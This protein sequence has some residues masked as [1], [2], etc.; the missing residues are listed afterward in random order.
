MESFVF[1][2]NDKLKL[3][4]YDSLVS[5]AEKCEEEFFEI[6][7][8]SDEE[9]QVLF[10]LLGID[11]PAEQDLSNSEDFYKL[12]DY[13]SYKLPEFNSEQFDEFYDA[14]LKR[15]GRESD[16]DEY[17]QLIFIQGQAANWN[18][19]TSRIVLHAKR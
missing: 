15:T 17:G 19:N 7:L 2:S 3:S 13:S 11:E 4:D 1:A 12:Y 5:F 10:N 6:V 16:M 14:W 9:L 8:N 18:E